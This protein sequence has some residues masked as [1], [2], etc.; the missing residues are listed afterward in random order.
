MPK[1]SDTTEVKSRDAT[2]ADA[3]YWK[4]L[5]KKGTQVI[6]P[7]RTG[8]EAGQR[9]NSTQR[10]IIL[11]QRDAVFNSAEVPVSL[12]DCEPN[13]EQDD[14]DFEAAFRPQQIALRQRNTNTSPLLE[15]SASRPGN[16]SGLIRTRTHMQDDV[17][18]NSIDGSP[19]A[20]LGPGGADPFGTLPSDLPKAFLE[21]RLYTSK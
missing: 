6:L 7:I 18:S 4:R 12:N 17:G 21:E 9:I 19:Y 20:I 5:P 1:R 10:A 14:D 8:R 13:L 11:R 3:R 15:T 2:R 16:Y